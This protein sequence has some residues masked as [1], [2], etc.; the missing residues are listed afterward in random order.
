MFGV[1][2]FSSRQREEKKLKVRTPRCEGHHTA[3][4]HQ[5]RWLLLCRVR[6]RQRPTDGEGQKGQRTRAQNGGRPETNERCVR[7]PRRRT[8]RARRRRLRSRTTAGCAR[9]MIVS[10]ASALTSSRDPWKSV[11]K[12]QSREPATIGLTTTTTT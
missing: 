7:A 8:R 5:P 11:T 12:R 6:A 1:R 2:E 9:P 10:I 3:D 4:D